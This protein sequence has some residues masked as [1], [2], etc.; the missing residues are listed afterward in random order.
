[1]LKSVCSFYSGNKIRKLETLLAHALETGCTGVQTG[2]GIG[3]NHV[4]ATSVHAKRS[5]LRCQAILVPQPNSRSVGQNL[6]WTLH[7]GTKVFLCPDHKQYRQTQ[8]HAMDHYQRKFGSE[9]SLIL[10]GGS[11]PMG[12]V[13]F[14]SAALELAEQIREGVCPKPD[15]IYLPLGTMG[16]AVGLTL[17]FALINLDINVVP[18]RVVSKSI[19][20]GS[21]FSSLFTQTNALLNQLNPSI[22]ILSP[23]TPPIRD[24]WFGSGYGEFTAE[25]Q[26]AVRLFKPLGIGLEG[27]YT[28]KTVA[29]MLSDMSSGTTAG[30]TVMYWMTYNRVAAPNTLDTVQLPDELE[31]LVNRPFQPLDQ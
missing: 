25:G 14:V 6:R 15:F 3:S 23:P 4:V 24:G 31:E 16:T 20:R 21:R 18:I 19:A 30:K 12:T 5:G 13:G 28:G 29:A 9:P 2:G 7:S 8:A 1:M 11:S 10:M 27:T 17:G 26:A 22:P